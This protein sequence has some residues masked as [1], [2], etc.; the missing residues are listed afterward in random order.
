MSDFK[1]W[2]SQ[3]PDSWFSCR[4]GKNGFLPV[5]S[6]LSVLPEKYNE[7]NVLLDK[8]RITQ[9]NGEKGYLSSGSLSEHVEKLPIYDF[10]NVKDIQL[11]AALHRDYCFLA[12]AYSLETCHLSLSKSDNNEYGTA[13]ETLPPQL[14]LP[15]LQLSKKNDTFP[16]LD[17]AYGYG[18]NN[19][20]LQEGGD[21]KDYKSYKTIRM[22]NGN[23]SEEGFINVHVAMVLARFAMSNHP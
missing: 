11:L 6:P 4:P 17:Y 22:F 21:Y 14:S 13:R 16:W 5:S 9:N 15:L 7:L 18:L 20:V 3:N 8:M 19:S 1:V 12:S 10:E 2:N 23:D